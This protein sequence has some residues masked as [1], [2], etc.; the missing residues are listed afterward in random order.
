MSDKKISQLTASTTPLAGTEV[1]AIVQSG[2][3]VQSTVNSLVNDR[4]I[5]PDSGNFSK[6]TVGDV[7]T[8]T[9]DAVGSKKGFLYADTQ[10]LAMLTIGGAGNGSGIL[11]D[12]NSGNVFLNT[13]GGTKLGLNASTGDAT[14]NTGNLVIGTAGKGI[15]FSADGQAA[16]MTSELLDDYEEGTWTPVIQ[17]SGT[18]GTYELDA[19]TKCEYTKIGR[20][21]TLVVRI[22]L[23]PTVTGGGV[24]DLYILGAPFTKS[25]NQ[26]AMGSVYLALGTFTGNLPAVSFNSLEGTSTTL[27]FPQSVSGGYGTSLPISFA[28]ANAYI[29]FTISYFV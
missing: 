27:Y 7:I 12:G 4:V 22:R 19:N 3:T 11:I 9:S 5:A 24:G 21:I 28:S 14:V 13:V 15:D 20:L 8:W 18:A 10:Y 17:G 16:G 1:L 25:L 6:S 23:A 29:G 26:I 2:S